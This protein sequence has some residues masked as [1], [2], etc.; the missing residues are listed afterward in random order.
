MLHLLLSLLF[1]LQGFAARGLSTP[2]TY[3]TTFATGTENPISDGGTGWVNGGVTGLDWTDVQT[4]TNKAFGTQSVGNHGSCGGCTYND[5]IALKNPLAG[6]SW[7]NDVTITAR[8]FITS[9]SGWTGN[10]EVELIQ[11][12]SMV[13]HR[14][15]LYEASLSVIGGTTYY[16]IV[17]WNGQVGVNDTGCASGCAYDILSIVNCTSV[18]DLTYIRFISSGTLLTIQTSTDDISYATAC[19]GTAFWDTSGDTVKYAGGLPGMGWWTN[20][21][22]AVNTYGLSQWRAQ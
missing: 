9:R 2:A 11:R 1:G 5:S 17:R 15:R 20:G 10:H 16:A 3:S 13:G 8:V 4:T 18:D 7:A 6:H 19:S 22:G 21:A 14:L 12:A